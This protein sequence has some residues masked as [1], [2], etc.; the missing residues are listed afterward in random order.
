MH[1]G[2]FGASN[3]Y[4]AGPLSR[5][6]LDCVKL[7]NAIEVSAP[8]HIQFQSGFMVLEKASKVMV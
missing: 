1:I 6:I 8:G 7:S 2:V 4:L 5:K 3:Q